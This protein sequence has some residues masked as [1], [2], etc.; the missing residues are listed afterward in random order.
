MATHP[1]SFH[2]RAASL[3]ARL[4]AG[5]LL[6]VTLAAQATVAPPVQA[7]D[8]VMRIP[9]A[10][11]SSTL[12]FVV[13][14]SQREARLVGASTPVAG[15]VE[16]KTMKRQ[17]SEV[18]MEPV[19]S[20]PLPAGAE[21]RLRTGVGEHFLMVQHVRKPL[22]PGQQ[23]PV[24]L[25]LEENGHPFALRLQAQVVAPKSYSAVPEEDVH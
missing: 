25:R 17:G 3:A 22:K 12:L 5:S 6:C 10:G 7:S 13:L 20:V 19:A 24:T 4:L 14:R 15:V 11:F 18:F 21:V 1:T 16:L 9:K 23:V 2:A 8:A